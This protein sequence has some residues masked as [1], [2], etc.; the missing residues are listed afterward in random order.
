ML[1]KSRESNKSSFSSVI[2]PLYIL[3]IS[4]LTRIEK[5]VETQ[6]YEGCSKSI[7]PLVGKNTVIYLGV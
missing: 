7:G 4:R 6:L 1:K 3:E 2:S 5:A